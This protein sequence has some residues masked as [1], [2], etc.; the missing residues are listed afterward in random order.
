VFAANDT[1]PPTHV[2]NDGEVKLIVGVGVTTPAETA[3]ELLHSPG[4]CE[5]DTRYAPVVVALAALIVK[6]GSVL[7]TAD[8]VVEPTA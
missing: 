4:H 8:Q 1:E 3:T 6:V 7:V 2:V 5:L